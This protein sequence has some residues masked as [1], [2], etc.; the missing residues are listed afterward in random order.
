MTCIYK[1]NVSLNS[2]KY[3]ILKD[4]IMY[5]P[6]MQVLTLLFHEHSCMQR[7]KQYNYSSF[8][9]MLKCCSVESAHMSYNSLGDD[10]P[11]HFF[12]SER[13]LY[14]VVYN[15]ISAQC[16]SCAS[17]TWHVFVVLKA[18]QVTKCSNGLHHC[19]HFSSVQSGKSKHESC[20]VVCH[21][22]VTWNER[23]I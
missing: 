14:P 7:T 9:F 12:C 5:W 8:F 1:L 2:G 6:V 16:C 22:D 21:K 18:Q 19:G 11:R 23:S 10:H 3:T 17:G 13:R 4:A 20:S 15:R